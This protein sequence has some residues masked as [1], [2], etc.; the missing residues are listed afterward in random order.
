MLP[1]HTPEVFILPRGWDRP[2]CGREVERVVANIAKERPDDAFLRRWMLRQWGN[3]SVFVSYELLCSIWTLARLG[4]VTEIEKL[5]QVGSSPNG[6]FARALADTWDLLEVSRADAVTAVRNIVD[7]G[8]DDP[9]ATS[10]EVARCRWISEGDLT[11]IGDLADQA[12]HDDTR[13]VDLAAAVS[14]LAGRVEAD[15]DRFCPPRVADL[16]AGQIRR[17]AES[18]G[19][20]VESDPQIRREVHEQVAAAGLAADADR[21]IPLGVEALRRGLTDE[22]SEA[23]ARRAAGELDWADDLH[24]TLGIT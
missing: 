16:E 7:L 15:P 6:S 4:R 8:G 5:T 20:E 22:F 17:L 1:S 14:A 21:L 13:R 2:S 10:S 3:A 18:A 24:E 19:L 9:A 11:R 12:R 23:L